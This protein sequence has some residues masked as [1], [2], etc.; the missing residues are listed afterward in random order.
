MMGR[1]ASYQTLLS[2]IAAV[3]GWLILWAWLTR[4]GGPV[5]ALYFPPPED[6]LEPLLAHVDQALYRQHAPRAYS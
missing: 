3:A 1:L 4:D 2:G 6:V 5:P